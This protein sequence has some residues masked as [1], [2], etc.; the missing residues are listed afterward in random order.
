[1]SVAASTLASMAFWTFAGTAT[2]SD[3]SCDCT[4]ATS[5]SI[6]TRRA[7]ASLA[8]WVRSAFGSMVVTDFCTDTMRF[9]APAV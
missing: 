6:A 4:W 2:A 5:F 8:A 9:W 3:W 1:M 7:L